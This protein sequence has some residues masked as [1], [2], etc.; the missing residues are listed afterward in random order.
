[1]NDV[2]LLRRMSD[3]DSRIVLDGKKLF[4]EFKG[5][6]I[7]NYVANTLN[8]LLNE[9]PN[10]FTFDRNEI[11]FVI[12]KNNKIIPIEVKSNK[13]TNNNNLTKYNAKND[14]EVSFRF[15]L[16]NLSRNDKII[17]I[18]LYF[19]EYINDLNLD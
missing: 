19:I 12:Q 2:R 18:P 6:F 1:M 3:L 5:S 15:S 9:S 17:N 8:Y 11:D 16:N 7:E 14:N 10:Y 13:T 4:E